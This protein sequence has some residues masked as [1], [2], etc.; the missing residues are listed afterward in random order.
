MQNFRPIRVLSEK[1]KEAIWAIFE[2]VA[3]VDQAVVDS[4]EQ[5]LRRIADIINLDPYKFEKETGLIWYPYDSWAEYIESK[6]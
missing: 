6:F 4:Y 1:D 2:Y 3:N 5:E